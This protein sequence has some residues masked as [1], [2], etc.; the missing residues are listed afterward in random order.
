MDFVCPKLTLL[1]QDDHVCCMMLKVTATEVIQLSKWL[2]W[3]QITIECFVVL[4][5]LFF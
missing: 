1:I 4:Q 2:P 5:H 3:S